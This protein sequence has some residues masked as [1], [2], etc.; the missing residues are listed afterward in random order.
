M[1]IISINISSSDSFFRRLFNK[2]LYTLTIR[3]QLSEELDE[4][5]DWFKQ[6]LGGGYPPKSM[7]R[8]AVKWKSISTNDFASI[9]VYSD[10]D[11]ALFKLTWMD[12][13]GKNTL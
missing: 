12:K 5:F 1:G 10:S 13:I 6:T 3:T 8:W 9:D 4:I 11:L 7:W 2:P